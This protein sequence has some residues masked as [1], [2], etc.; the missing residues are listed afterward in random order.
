M[1]VLVIYLFILY[2]ILG[3]TGA[4]LLIFAPYKLYKSYRKSK[5]LPKKYVLMVISAVVLLF[6]QSLVNAA[7]QNDGT[8]YSEEKLAGTNLQIYEPKTTIDGSGIESVSLSGDRYV[9]EYVSEG[10]IYR[11]LESTLADYEESGAGFGIGMD[12]YI[13][14]K[15]IANLNKLRQKV[16]TTGYSDGRPSEETVTNPDAPKIRNDCL[17][18]GKAQD[19]TEV[20]VDKS[21]YETGRGS[22]NALAQINGTVIVLKMNKKVSKD[23]L[24]DYFEHLEYTK[25][26]DVDFTNKRNRLLI[27]NYL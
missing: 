10:A 25:P 9:I 14:K 8:E 15:L 2:N 20:F 24:L 3:L 26:T 17:S 1:E 7:Q 11:L 22:Y 23:K 4:A 13:S 5:T 27:I 18:L 21:R 12:C 6:G 19:G 16:I